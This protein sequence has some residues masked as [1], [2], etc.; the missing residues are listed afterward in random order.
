MREWLVKENKN[1]LTIQKYKMANFSSRK[2]T[3]MLD[4]IFDFYTISFGL[5][6][7]NNLNK[8]LSEAYRVLKTWW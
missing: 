7:T 2:V 3:S 6:N 8:A 5:R 1:F 4:N